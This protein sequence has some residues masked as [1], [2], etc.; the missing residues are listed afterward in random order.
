MPP[1]RRLNCSGLLLN[2]SPGLSPGRKEPIRPCKPVA[3]F[4]RC[5]YVNLTHIAST[6]KPLFRTM[7]LVESLLNQL[8]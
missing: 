1:G 2:L 7:S 4:V 5:Q 3:V 6:R 8:H